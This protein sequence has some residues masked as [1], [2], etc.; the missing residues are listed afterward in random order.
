MEHL[1]INTISNWGRCRHK[2][3]LYLLFLG[4]W[5][6]TISIS[7]QFDGK[8]IIM[9]PKDQVIVQRCFIGVEGKKSTFC[10]AVGDPGGI[11]YAMDLSQGALINIW[12]GGFIDA[13]TM[14]T[15]RGEEQ[16]AK[17]LGENVI[18]LVS[19]PNFAPL[20]DKEQVWPDSTQTLDRF[21]FKGYKLDQQG[22]P[23][24]RYKLGGVTI[25]DKIEPANNDQNLTR[26]V[27][28]S[29]KN[30]QSQIWIRLAKG[31]SIKKIKKNSYNV[32][33]KNYRID[34]V[35]NK[36]Q[37][38]IIRRA[39]GGMELIVPVAMNENQGEVK[40]SIIR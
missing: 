6:Y 13:T 1:K 17:P 24:F 19:E 38:P 12:K 36:K 21:R 28:I 14:W 9:T 18:K 7:A 39:D 3:I 2:N 25:W 30:T 10:V 22:R 34:L 20:R 29:G 15:S 11:N 31:Q 33:D 35:S 37:K 4:C 23:T 26:T 27:K 8:P 5:S 16:L 32:P 40:Y